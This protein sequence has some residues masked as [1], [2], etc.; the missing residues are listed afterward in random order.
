MSKSADVT[1]IRVHGVG[2]T[3]PQDLLGD[4]DPELVW[5]D[6]IAGFHRSKRPGK[7][8]VEAYSWGGLTSRSATRILWLILLPFMLANLAG[9]MC[10]KNLHGSRWFWFHRWLVRWVGLALTLNLL[11]VTAMITM[12][13]VGYQ[14]GGQPT[15]ASGYWWLRPLRWLE[16][17]PGLRLAVGAAI[18][19]LV[20]GLIAL[21][22]WRTRM[23]YE[24]VPPPGVGE[25]RQQ[26]ETSAAMKGIGIDDP[27]FWNS[28]RATRRLA[29]V[30]L[31][32]SLAMLALVLVHTAHS[33]APQPGTGIIAGMAF[34]GVWGLG[35]AVL[36]ASLYLIGRDNYSRKVECFLVGSAMV[37]FVAAFG[38]AWAQRIDGGSG[39]LPGMRWVANIGYAAVW[40]PVVMMAFF[41]VVRAIGNWRKTRSKQ[42]SFTWGAPFVLLALAVITL[43]SFMI[44]L[45][46]LLAE[47]LG[48][49]EW[50]D[51]E[52]DV[53]ADAIAVFLFMPA[54]T[55]WLTLAPLALLLV[56]GIVELV[57]YLRARK[58]TEQV[59]SGYG[60]L[61]SEHLE[62][63]RSEPEAL[64][65]WDVSAL[66]AP[67]QDAYVARIARKWTRQVAGVRRLAAATT[68]VAYLLSTIAVVVMGALVYVWWN[69]EMPVE[70]A[71]GV[72]VAAA[73]LL[74]AAVLAAAR[75]GWRDLQKR[76]LLGVLWDVGTFFPRAYHPLAPPCY[77]ERA[78]PDLQ[79]RIWWLHDNG[80]RVL[81]STHSQG[82]I[83]A[84]A[85][86]SQ[87]AQRNSCD[88]VAL[89]TFGS[90]LAKL[91][92]WG[93]PA[94]FGAETLACFNERRN[95]VVWRNQFYDTDY[96]G[97]PVGIED[98]DRELP[99][100]AQCWYD[101]G[102][103]PPS[104]RSHTGYWNDPAVLDCAE[105]LSNCL[106]TRDMSTLRLLWSNVCSVYLRSERRSGRD[107]R[108]RR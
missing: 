101:Y 53:A 71:V 10:T 80:H 50:T 35:S 59:S 12:D 20:I 24:S 95:V 28:A 105:E 74:P 57:L 36:V 9:W 34:Y 96:I 30:H 33:A 17:L 55:P 29:Q 3:T 60:K 43:N 79:R 61:V 16:H 41:L 70:R 75:W 97:G 18:P 103:P 44:G 86:R 5:G 47:V 72:G 68:D 52:G 66:P 106:R 83:L 108:R 91:Y 19:A 82:T 89:Q 39:H 21:L 54:A 76:R 45:L 87:S 32:A 62:A 11:L 1:K 25:S 13:V 88:L 40:L 90:P 27:D 63:V 58:S 56:F 73:M 2:G 37:A 26:S 104:I 4:S 85:A 64:G 98:V 7:R 99:D 67:G 102:Q 48:R 78:V 51:A 94:Y 42:K 92:G 100:P 22:A 49:P 8:G 69:H 38:Y 84:V 6:R 31:G 81:L 107:R 93:F 46:I 65:L 77:A 14:C 23:R 15:C